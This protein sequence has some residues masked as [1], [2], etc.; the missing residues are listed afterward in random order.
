MLLHYVV[1]TH[2]SLQ[3]CYCDTASLQICRHKY[4]IAIRRHNKYVVTN[5]LLQYGVTTNT[6][7]R[8]VWVPWRCTSPK[9]RYH[10]FIIVANTLLQSTYH[11]NQCIIIINALLQSMHYHNRYGVIINTSL[12]QM[13]A[14]WLSRCLEVQEKWRPLLL[15]SWL[16]YSIITNTALWLLCHHNPH[17]VIAKMSL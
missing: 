7:R 14:G 13:R 17:V 16:L 11:C 5:M 6:C 4:V 2:T 8:V 15:E 12:Q 3:V 9:L 1:T 10:E